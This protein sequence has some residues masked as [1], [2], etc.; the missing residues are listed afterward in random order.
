MHVML[1]SQE[2]FVL[3]YGAFDTLSSIYMKGTS[4]IFHRASHKR[5][6]TLELLIGSGI[7]NPLPALLSLPYKEGKVST[8]LE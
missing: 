2:C 3:G 6:R 4:F 1:L 7:E 8:K 5:H